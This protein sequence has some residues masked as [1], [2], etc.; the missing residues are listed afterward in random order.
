MPPRG[1]SLSSLQSYVEGYGFP[2]SGNGLKNSRTVAT[3]LKMGIET[4]VGRTPELATPSQVIHGGLTNGLIEEV[5]PVSKN[6]A[7]DLLA[8]QNCPPGQIC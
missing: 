6:E 7:K 1:G 5:K 2:S 3:M 8:Q 4:Q